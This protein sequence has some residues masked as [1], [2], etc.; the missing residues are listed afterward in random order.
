[1]FAG[2][3]AVRAAGT[4]FRSF[5][6]FKDGVTINK[7]RSLSDSG[8]LRNDIGRADLNGGVIS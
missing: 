8:E 3:G 7:A 6:G 2:K 4:I 1:M 5:I